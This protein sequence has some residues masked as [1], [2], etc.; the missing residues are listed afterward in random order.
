MDTRIKILLVEDH[1]DSANAITRL[2]EMEGY[3]V[4]PVENI[5]TALAAATTHEFDLV[6]CDIGLPDGDGCALIKEL[7][8]AYNLDGIAL[9]GLA[10]PDEIERLQKAG[11]VYC[12]TKPVTFENLEAAIG[13]FLWRH[14]QEC[15]PA[16]EV[17][18]G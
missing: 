16:S 17:W 9:T 11:F 12:I 14:R 5:R 13:L 10:M 1:T 18:F 15:G 7:R 2:L 3:E 6:I 4:F 8:A